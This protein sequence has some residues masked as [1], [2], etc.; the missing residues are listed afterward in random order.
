M[1]RIWTQIQMKYKLL[2][3]AFLIS[4]ASVVAVI[5]VM[6]VVP[7]TNG[8][9]HAC[10]TTGGLFPNGATRIINSPTQSCNANETAISWN[11]STP[12]QLVDNLVGAKFGGA[13]LHYRNFA[14]ADLHNAQFGGSNH[15]FDA[16]YLTGANFQG[17][18]LS[19]VVF[20]EIIEENT[21]NTIWAEDA[22]FQGANFSNAAFSNANLRGGNFQGV[23]FANTSFNASEMSNANFSGA[24]FRTAQFSN[25]PLLVPELVHFGGLANLSN[26]NFTGT[27]VTRVSFHGNLSATNFTNAHFDQ[28]SFQG[29]NLSTAVLTGATWTNT[30]CPDNT[31]S[32]NNGNTCIGHLIP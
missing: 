4:G 30:I 20:G 17:A 8:V 12:G 27:A 1:R 16:T 2:M 32:D 31:N 7:D 21:G 13:S 10:Y 15:R 25:D 23:N 28:A 6:A 5:G 9:I 26:A 29:A 11:K 22:N 24:D 18:N 14:G 19:G 3:A